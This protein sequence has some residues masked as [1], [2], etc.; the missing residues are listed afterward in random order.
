MKRRQILVT[1]AAALAV[2]PGVPA[3][4]RVPR[5]W[6][7]EVP[8]TEKDRILGDPEAPITIIEYASLTCPACARFHKETL[9]D[10]KKKWI[11][12][13]KARLVY[14]NFPI[15]GLALR[16]ATV[17]SCVEGDAYFSFLDALFRGQ[18]Q[19]SRAKDPTAALAQVARFA[20]IDQRAFDACIS[21]KAEMDRILKQKVE[22]SQAYDVESTPTF[23][24]NGEK[25]EGALGPA[26]FGKALAKAE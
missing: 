16:A 18:S 9:P 19:W 14:R 26:Q 4:L 20:G 2:L 7:G 17:A 3:L 6:A 8:V 5:A 22:G 23:I 25:V 12:P 1:G 24:I 13:G 15:D 10:V 21:D 11:E